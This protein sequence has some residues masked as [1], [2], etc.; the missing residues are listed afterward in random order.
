MGKPC[1]P[2]GIVV[3]PGMKKNPVIKM[4]IMK[5]QM[6]HNVAGPIITICYPYILFNV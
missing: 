6:P 3:S 4:I 2:D 1:F 5:K